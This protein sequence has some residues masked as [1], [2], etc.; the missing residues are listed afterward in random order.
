MRPWDYSA[1][2]KPFGPEFR[3]WVVKISK[4]QGGISA[5]KRDALREEASAMDL[6]ER[7]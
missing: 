3:A 7:S 2:E 4:K 5:P 6:A 1:L